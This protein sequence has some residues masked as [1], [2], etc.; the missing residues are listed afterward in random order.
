MIKM[1]MRMRNDD[2]NENLN[3]LASYISEYPLWNME[4][5]E[6]EFEV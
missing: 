2:E 5:M 4:I 1:R 3:G 6:H